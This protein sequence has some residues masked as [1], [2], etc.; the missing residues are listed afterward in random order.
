MSV[1]DGHGRSEVWTVQT[2]CIDGKKLKL[3]LI[4]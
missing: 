2:E 1:V 3:V 4:E